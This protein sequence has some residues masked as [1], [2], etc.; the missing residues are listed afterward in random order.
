MRNRVRKQSS[1][2]LGVQ[3]GPVVSSGPVVTKTPHDALFKSVFQHPENAAAELQHVLAPEHVSA[4]DWSTLKLEV[5]L[6]T[7][8]SWLSELG[9]PV[10]LSHLLYVEVQSFLLGCGGWKFCRV[11]AGASLSGFVSK[12]SPCRVQSRE[13]ERE[14]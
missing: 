9:S 4:I 7:A 1:E 13:S 2:E 8:R 6:C 5:F 3:V 10:L 12:G 14:K 11:G